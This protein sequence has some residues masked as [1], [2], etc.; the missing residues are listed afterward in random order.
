MTRLA[1]DAKKEGSLSL[2]TSRVAEDT[3]PLT[4]AFTRKYGVGVQVWRASNQD[5]I[6]RR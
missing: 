6:Q 2:Y 3:T 5:I 4:D 1:A